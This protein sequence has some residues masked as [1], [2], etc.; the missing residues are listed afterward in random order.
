MAVTILR[1]TGFWGAW[2]KLSL[3]V[4]DEEITTISDGQTVTFDLPTYPTYI[5]IKGDPKSAVLVSDHHQYIL[6]THPQFVWAQVLAANI[7]ILSAF[8][9]SLVIKMSMYL[10]FISLA[11]ILYFFLPHYSFKPL[12][13]PKIKIKKFC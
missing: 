1:K 13:G 11:I 9:P 10:C 7:L 3:I 12:I 2:G 6:C 5:S 4:Q 8:I